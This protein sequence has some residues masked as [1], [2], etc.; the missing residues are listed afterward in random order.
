MKGNNSKYRGDFYNTHKCEHCKCCQGPPGP[1]G[2]QGY[3]GPP[4]RQ[5]CPG[6]PG[7][8]G[9]RGAPGPPGK[10]GEPGPTG[11]P[12]PPGPSGDCC[13]LDSTL[14][15]LQTINIAD[16]NQNVSVTSFNTTKSGTIDSFLEGEVVVIEDAQSTKNYVSLCNILL[17]TFAVE[18]NI[19]ATDITYNCPTEE[20]CCNV[21]MEQALKTL[22]NSTEFPVTFSPSE[23][24]QINIVD[25][26][27]SPLNIITVYGICNGVIWVEFQSTVE[28]NK[29]GA[30]PLCSIF[31]ANIKK[32]DEE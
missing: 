16:S 4:G 24:L 23:A 3:P 22:I 13:C 14:Y 7:P 26:T 18:P 19:E 25:N 30:I 5:G 15:A 31:S 12:G 27:D 2:R 9:R 32:E 6:E 17:I 1:P 21:G 11:P 20:C 8:P 29:Y 28:G 10:Q